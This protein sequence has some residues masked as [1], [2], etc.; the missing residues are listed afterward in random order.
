MKVRS[1]DVV[2]PH[3]CALS[4]EDVLPPPIDTRA[5][6]DPRAE[7]P[8]YATRFVPSLSCG[9]GALVLIHDLRR[10]SERLSV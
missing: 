10:S 7:H 6:S 2:S 3:D 4:P 1:V 5:I 9:T 8:L